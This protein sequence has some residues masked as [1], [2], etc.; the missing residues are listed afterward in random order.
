[1]IFYG[2]ADHRLSG[3]DLGEVIDFYPSRE[4]AGQVLRD[5][6]ADE[7]SW[8]DDLGIVEVAFKGGSAN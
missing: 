7:P 8:A 5:V 4:E 2:L 3:S 6:I 1:M